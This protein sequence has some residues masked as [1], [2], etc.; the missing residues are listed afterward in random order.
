[1]IQILI[2]TLLQK[3]LWTIDDLE[4][5]Y[6]VLTRTADDYGH[7]IYRFKDGVFTPN[8]VIIDSGCVPGEVKKSLKVGGGMLEG[9]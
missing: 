5:R 1:M 9:L 4:T 7:L 2:E 8:G 3:K 6:T